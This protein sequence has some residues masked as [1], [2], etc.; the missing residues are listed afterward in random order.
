M[1][2]KYKYTFTVFTPTYNREKLIHRVFDSLKKQTFKDFEWLIVDDGSK[3]DTKK[4]IEEFKKQADFE[5]RYIY[6]ENGGKHRAFN[7]GVKEANG[8]LFL[9]ADSDDYFLENALEKFKY[10]WDLIP[11]KDEFSA[12]TGLCIDQNG[13]IVGDK[14]PE[15]IFDSNSF[16]TTFIYKIKGEKW[17][18]QR[19]DVLRQYPFKEF[20]GERF[21]AESS[22]WFELSK[23]YKTRYINEPV[24][25]YEI[26]NDSLSTNTIK[27]RINNPKGT[28][29]T[30]S[31]DFNLPIPFKFR[32]KSMINCLR[33]SFYDKTLLLNCLKIQKKLLLPFIFPIAFLMFIKDKYK[34]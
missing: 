26:N 6:Q 19:T 30:Y 11:N 17:G 2:V 5:I 33:F 13:Q 24:R 7:R 4:V 3:D 10:Y 29:Y 9:T 16:E 18:F 28:I 12:V 25:I 14:Y 31:K 22:V 27:L 20:E 34:K 8:E 21:I 15:N 32:I 23:K 1:D